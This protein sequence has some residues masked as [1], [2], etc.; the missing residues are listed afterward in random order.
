MMRGEIVT[1]YESCSYS[2]RTYCEWDT[3]YSEYGCTLGN[4]NPEENPCCYDNCP[5]NCEY[6]VKNEE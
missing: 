2:E 6:G 3:G 5:L 4:R 1:D